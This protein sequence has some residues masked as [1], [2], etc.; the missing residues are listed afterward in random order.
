MQQYKEDFIKFMIDCDV[1]KFGSFV[2]KSG[3]NTPFFINAGNFSTG[4]AIR[5]LGGFYAKSIMDIFKDDVEKGIDV[6][7][8]PAYKGICRGII[9]RR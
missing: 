2:T 4:S 5:K 9:C 1:L 6:I 3:R 7:F 8:G